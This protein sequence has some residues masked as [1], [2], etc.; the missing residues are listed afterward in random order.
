MLLD[1]IWPT[2]LELSNETREPLVVRW[3]AQGE[4]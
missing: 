4:E 1:R 2:K 3:Q